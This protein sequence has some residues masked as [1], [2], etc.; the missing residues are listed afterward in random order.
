M[1]IGQ[2]YIPI[3][4]G[5][6]NIERLLLQGFDSSQTDF[7]SR[8]MIQTDIFN[9]IL[10]GKFINVNSDD[11]SCPLHTSQNTQYSR[12]TP[13]IEHRL[14]RLKRQQLYKIPSIRGSLQRTKMP[15][16]LIPL[17]RIISPMPTSLQAHPFAIPISR[18]KLRASI[19]ISHGPTS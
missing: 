14:A 17:K 9:G 5:K 4:I 16:P 13:H 2:Q 10:D 11:G 7:N 8:Y 12:T 15:S 19:P 1:H 6:N 3:D 18:K